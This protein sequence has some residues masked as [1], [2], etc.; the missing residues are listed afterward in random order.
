MSEVKPPLGVM[1]KSIWREKRCAEL[2]RAIS[3]YVKDYRTEPV[4]AWL[5]ELD[6]H[7]AVLHKE[8]AR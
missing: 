6:H 8:E 4:R 7:I 3:E 1:P 2:A 5:D